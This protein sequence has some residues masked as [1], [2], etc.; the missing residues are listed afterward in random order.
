MKFI[1]LNLYDCLIFR[2]NGHEIELLHTQK[3]EAKKRQVGINSIEFLDGEKIV[4]GK[5]SRNCI[6]IMYKNFHNKTENLFK[7][8]TFSIG[9]HRPYY[10]NINIDAIK[11][12]DILY[13]E[14]ELNKVYS[15]F[16]L[17]IIYGIND[18]NDWTNELENMKC[19]LA[20]SKIIM[21]KAKS[22]LDEIEM[23]EKPRKGLSDAQVKLKISI[24]KYNSIKDKYDSHLNA[25]RETK[26]IG[27]DE[28]LK[29]IE[30][31]TDKYFLFN[32]ELYFTSTKKEPYRY[33]QDQLE[34]LL[35]EFIYK[36]NSKFEKLQKQI[37]L[38]EKISLEIDVER[39]REPIPEDVKFEVW[40]RDG[41]KCVICGSNEKLEFDHII[42]FSKGGSNT[43]RNIQLLCE[44]CNRKK[45]N[46]I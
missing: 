35:K 31:T 30:E 33:T 41:G 39:K 11:I 21:D 25:K 46:I 16:A 28:T 44:S 7:F 8:N 19:E 40:R 12:F 29:Y 2:D 34:I 24:E 27:R 18:M 15:Y 3:R 14:I 26:E 4:K 20:N 17:P 23:R 32:N 22:D 5:Y 1:K 38:F 10:R 6:G 42:P 9:R 36:E 37:D 13:D 43:A 45:S